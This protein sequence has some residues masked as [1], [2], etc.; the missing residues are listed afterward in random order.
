MDS[1]V[2]RSV[3]SAITDGLGEAPLVVPAMGGSGP[4]YL[5]ERALHTPVILLP[6]ANY[7][8]NQHASNENLRVRNLWDGI[9]LYAGLLARRG[10]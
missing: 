7:D 2:A 4:N 6:I 10:G 3:I 1:P 8:D 9:D 5:F